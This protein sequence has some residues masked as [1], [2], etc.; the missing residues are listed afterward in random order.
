LKLISVMRCSWWCAW[1]C[2]RSRDGRRHHEQDHERV[3]R[4]HHHREIAKRADLLRIAIECP[5]VMD[6]MVHVQDPRLQRPVHREAMHRPLEHV[7]HRP[8]HRQHRPLPASRAAGQPCATGKDHR[9]DAE[10]LREMTR[11]REAPIERGIAVRERV[12]RRHV[13]IM[14]PPRG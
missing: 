8:G 3:P 5:M 1:C 4:H 2:A 13:S 11:E 14:P 10:H 7:R 9:R 6:R 12:A